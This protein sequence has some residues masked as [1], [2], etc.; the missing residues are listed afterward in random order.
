MNAPRTWSAFMTR[1]RSR[2]VASTGLSF[3]WFSPSTQ[4]F[5]TLIVGTQACSPVFE[6]TKDVQ[7]KWSVVS[8]SLPV[9]AQIRL[10][11]GS[12]AYTRLDP[13]TPSA[14]IQAGTTFIFGVS[15]GGSATGSVTI[16]LLNH[17]DS[18]DICS[19]Q[20]TVIT[21]AE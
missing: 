4:E 16:Q 15:C 11:I 14:L 3:L 17:T 9:G 5:S 18:S 7:I 13:N 8:G 21:V 19:N 12:G 1:G 20:L 6:A 10:K 2:S